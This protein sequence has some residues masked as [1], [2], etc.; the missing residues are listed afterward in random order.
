MGRM[1]VHRQRFVESHHGTPPAKS[2]PISGAGED[3]RRSPPP[4]ADGRRE[5]V[6]EVVL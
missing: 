3:A 1:K 2:R 6:V 5:G 4:E